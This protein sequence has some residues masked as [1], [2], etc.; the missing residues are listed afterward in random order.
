MWPAILRDANAGHR[1]LVLF[2]MA[3]VAGAVAT[4]ARGLFDGRVIT[5][6]P[7]WNK[8]FKFFV[9]IAAY[10][11]TFAWYLGQIRRATGRHSR[12]ATW[13]GTGVGIALAV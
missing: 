2:S 5:G 3:C 4:L 7:V 12:V 13:L 1:G 8:P 10:T 9:S 6:A 11:F